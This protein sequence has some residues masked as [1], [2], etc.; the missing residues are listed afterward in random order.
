MDISHVQFTRHAHKAPRCAWC[1]VVPIVRTR[2]SLL[3]HFPAQWGCFDC[4]LR[5]VVNDDVMLILQCVCFHLSGEMG[6][7]DPRPATWDA[8]VDHRT[9]ADFPENLSTSPHL[10]CESHILN[11]TLLALHC[12]LFPETLEMQ[13][14][15]MSTKHVIFPTYHYQR[16]LLVWVCFTFRHLYVDSKK[17]RQRRKNREHTKLQY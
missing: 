2:Y 12:L 10:G 7:W 1:W 8:F 5:S 9:E 11:P 15:N 13:R 6:R 16:Y 4:L 14:R 17:R 3:I